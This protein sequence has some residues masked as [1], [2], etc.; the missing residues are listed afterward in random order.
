M[1]WPN[2]PLILALGTAVEALRDEMPI[3]LGP[4]V[5]VGSGHAIIEFLK[6]T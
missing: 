6:K 5:Y 4:P 3:D 2:G 1:I